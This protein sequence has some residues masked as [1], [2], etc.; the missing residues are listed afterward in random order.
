MWIHDQTLL[1]DRA[2]FGVFAKNYT[3]VDAAGFV[4]SFFC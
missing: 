1:G 3:H 2:S 4:K